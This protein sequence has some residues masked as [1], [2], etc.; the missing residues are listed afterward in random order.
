LI[1][2]YF[3]EK[4]KLAGQINLLSLGFATLLSYCVL[5]YFVDMHANV[6]EGIQVSYLI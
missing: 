6:A 1:L 4:Q 3:I 2:S 5:S